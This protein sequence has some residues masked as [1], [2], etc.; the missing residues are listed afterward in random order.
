VVNASV[1]QEMDAKWQR[2]FLTWGILVAVFGMRL[3]FPILIVAI[4]TGL[5]SLDVLHMAINQPDD[6]ARYLT[7]A[8]VGIA[9]FGGM[10]LLLVFLAFVLDEGKDIHWLRT[11]EEPL[12]RLGK[13]ESI[14]MICALILLLAAQSFLPE[15]DRLTAMMAGVGGIILFVILD[16]LAG[17]FEDKTVGEGVEQTAKRAGIMSFIYLEIL[18]ASFSFDGVIGAFAITKD[19]VI[20]ML[21]LGI[22]ALFVRSMTIFLVEH[23]T[24]ETYVF[25]EH[26]AHYAIGVLAVIMLVSMVVHVSELVTGLIGV[27]FIVLSVVSSVR[28]RRAQAHAVQ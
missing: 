25:L 3:V 1:L 9:A 21:G 6:Y 11:L 26:G 7:D 20:I 23:G 22:G 2:Y 12:V 10:F 4:A 8:Y 17:L 14:E 16:S 15:R 13:L 24:L 28:H 19:V 5:G 27:L 18:D